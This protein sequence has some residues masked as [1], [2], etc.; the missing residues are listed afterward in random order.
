MSEA[1]EA[2][3]T[4]SINNIGSNFVVIG[5]IISFIA[6]SISVSSPWILDYLRPLP[7]PQKEENIAQTHQNQGIYR[8]LYS[9]II[10][11]KNKE[12][13][14]KNAKL[15]SKQEEKELQPDRH[16]TDNWSYIVMI[17]AFG[18]MVSSVIGLLQRQNKYIGWIGIFLGGAAIMLQ[19][20]VITLIILAI[21]VFFI[22][23]LSAMGVEF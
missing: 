20:I 6:F 17:I 14:D 5:L 1:L 3:K 11:D 7:S 16:W 2:Q 12:N 9:F 10:F 8:W 23:L 15:E 18:G 13:I 21:I 4:Q 19:Y 22:F